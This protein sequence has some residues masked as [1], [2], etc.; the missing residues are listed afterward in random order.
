MSGAGVVFHLPSEWL[1]PS[2]RG[3]SV[4]ADCPKFYQ[5]AIDGLK[6]QQVSVALE[7]LERDTLRERVDADEKFHILHDGSF[8]HERAMIAAPAYVAPFWHLDAIGGRRCSSIA[9]KNFRAHEVDSTRA[10]HLFNA[11]RLMRVKT[12]P[13][14]VPDNSLLVL[15]Q[16]PKATRAPA[17]MTRWE[18]LETA[19]ETWEGPV[20]LRLHPEARDE[21]VLER[22]SQ[23]QFIHPQLRL[24]EDHITA[25]LPAVARV[26]SINSGMTLEAHLHRTPSI[27]C[28]K[29]DFHHVSQVAQTREILA[30]ILSAPAPKRAHA[31]YLHWYFAGNCMNENAPDIGAEVIRRIHAQGYNIYETRLS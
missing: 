7:P 1:E 5:S 16:K 27:L 18:M 12:E 29:A 10:S 21:G 25:L 4:A 20:L 22:V 13:A 6:D 17:Y 28:G 31:K 8:P 24:V 30:E 14:V 26:L 19:L 2:G 3:I 23:L 11:M 9:D 15:F